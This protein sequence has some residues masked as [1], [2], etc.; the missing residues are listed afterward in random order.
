MEGMLLFAPP[1]VGMPVPLEF[2]VRNRGGLFISA[3]GVPIVRGTWFQYYEPDW[4]R[5]YYSSQFSDQVITKKENGDILM[6][7]RGRDDKASG[8]QKFTRTENGVKIECEF[9]WKGDGP[10][11]L[12]FT[13]GLLWAKA[14]GAGSLTINGQPTRSLNFQTYANATDPGPRTY[15]TGSTFRFTAPFG[16]LTLTGSGQPFTI[17]DGRGY[18]Q[19]WATSRDIYWMGV[20]GMDLEPNVPK[21]LT[22]EYKFEPNRVN[23]RVEKPKLEAVSLPAARVPQNRDFPILP[24]PKQ[25]TLDPQFPPFDLNPDTLA[26][27]VPVPYENATRELMS[28][29]KRGFELPKMTFLNDRRARIMVRVEGRDLPAEGYEIRVSES[30]VSVFAQ[31][32]P[33]VRNAMRTLAMLAFTQ[34]GKL[35]LPACLIRDWPSISWRGVHLFG[36]PEIRSFHSRM[37]NRIF[38]PLKINK[39]VLQCERTKWKSQPK[40][41]TP[42]FNSREDLRAVFEMYRQMG[43][44]PIPLIQSLGHMEWFFNNGANLDLAINKE[45]PY[46]VN[47]AKPETE[48]TI[49]ALWDEAIDLLKPRAIHFGLDEIDM[50]GMPDDPPNTTRVWSQMMPTLMRIANKHDVRPIFWGDKGLA[51]GQAIDAALGDNPIEAKKRRD[52]LPRGAWIADWHYKND[53][54]PDRFLWSINLW[55]QEGFWPIASTWFN[56]DNIRGFSQAAY[57]SGSGFLQTTWAGYEHDADSMVRDFRQV[58]AYVLAADYAWSGRTEMPSALDYDPFYVFTRMYYDEP[59]VLTPLTGQ[60]LGTGTPM[61]IGAVAFRRISP[62]RLYSVLTHATNDLPTEVEI[63]PERLEG[64]TVALAATTGMELEDNDPVAN[65]I[66]EYADG[67]TAAQTL[68][69]GPDVRFLGDKAKIYRGHRSESGLCLV[70]IPLDRRAPIKRITVRASSSFAGLEIHGITVY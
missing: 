55:K 8:T 56:P 30:L 6:T 45:I 67:Q 33:G 58:T 19:P 10:V 44:E 41:H 37:A 13:G 69:Y 4:S 12:E 70:R 3:S 60:S 42:L 21:S 16:D 22:L 48:K 57:K 25:A 64:R 5:G 61:T 20:L 51:P 46:T 38:S 27:D 63:A 17:F 62:L 23:R 40:I 31:D 26:I 34:N 68:L 53:P 9:L 1:D 28:G 65:V 43:I 7:F 32:E 24:K 39:I 36:G 29:L 47:P 2:D 35:Y 66:V 11:K 54:Q 50:R 52:A 49:S 15:G 59:S 18:A 14:F